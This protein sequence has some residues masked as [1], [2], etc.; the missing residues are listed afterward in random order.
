[1][2]LHHIMILLLS[3][4]PLA[5][6][7]TILSAN[8]IAAVHPER[9]PLLTDSEGEGFHVVCRMPPGTILPRDNRNAQREFVLD[10]YDPGP[11]P[12]GDYL[13]WTA[14]T[15]DGGRVL[16]TNRVTDNL[17]VF[18][19]QTMEILATVELGEYPS[20]VAANE[21]YAVVAC[22]FG[23]EVHVIDLSTYDTA[24]VFPTSE[25]PWVV[26][27]SHD[28]WTA[29]VSC[30]I[31]DVCEVIDLGEMSHTTTLTDFP[32]WL[33]SFAFNTGSPRNYFQFTDFLVS[34]DGEHLIAYDGDDSLVFINSTSGAVDHSVEIAT[35]CRAL[36]LSGD[37][38]RVVAVCATTPAQAFQVDLAAYELSTSLTIDG[39]SL[40]FSS[41]GVNWDGSKAFVGVSD[42]SSAILRFDTGDFTVFTSTY[43]AFWIGVSPDHSLVASGQYRFAVLDFATETILGMHVGNSQ[44]MGT[45]SP[46]EFRAA[47]YDPMR[48]E[49]VYFY[50]FS[51][52]DHEPD[53]L[54]SVISGEA[55]EGD[56]PKRVVLTPDGEMA[57]LTGYMSDNVLVLDAASGNV[58]A[59]IPADD[60]V[61]DLAV[62]PDSRWAVVTDYSAT[63]KVIDL[64]NLTL[65]A[66]VTAG[67]RAAEVSISPDGA[68]AYAAC[69]LSDL[70]T[71]V[72]LDGA[73]SHD[74]AHLPCGELGVVWSNYGTFSDVECSPAGDVALVTASFDDVVKVIDMQSLQITA[75]LP[76][77]DFPVQAAFSADGTRAAIC[78][79]FSDDVSLLA[80][81]NGEVSVLGIFPTGDGP[82]RL[83]YNP[84][85]DVFGICNYTQ[86]TLSYMDA[87]TGDITHTDSYED[88]GNLVQARFDE[89]GLPIVL[90]GGD[91]EAPGR[92]HHGE[93]VIDLP[94]PGSYFD[95]HEDSRT[96]AVAIPGPDFLSLVRFGPRAPPAPENLSISRHGPRVMLDWDPVEG[97]VSYAVYSSNSA[98]EGFTDAPGGQVTETH[99][100]G[101]LSHGSRFFRVTAQGLE[102]P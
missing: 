31:D 80:V 27:L 24:A 50:D 77:G 98:W 102:G 32:V 36:A 54:G 53:F 86:K 1:M 25:Q 51:G 88:Y 66:E 46:V 33:Q 79:Y 97:A 9:P 7:E 19:A 23:D 21:L 5:V 69:I 10:N 74:V 38:S 2:S 96:A 70:V 17:T 11:S 62:T 72:E 89:E 82:L 56:A 28:G 75:S 8:G 14:W 48:H 93:D 78:N 47:G 92:L 22:S 15:P 43:T 37:G 76:V 84:A 73:N 83:C 3:L 60:Q 59:V 99:W 41:L 42:N 12:E 29:Y 44:Y 100:S 13:G 4:P 30:D 95:Y 65:A 64:E 61:Q 20:G 71:I 90:T 91:D 40:M 26:R 58:L 81:E 6:G 101:Q 87:S 67:E 63:V 85:S 18:D 16:M 39:Y 34:P 35:S 49:G 68:Y 52:P 94:G 57:V 45:V 55:P